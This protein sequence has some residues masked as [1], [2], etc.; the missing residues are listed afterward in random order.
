MKARQQSHP[1]RKTPPSLVEL[2]QLCSA[3]DGHKTAYTF[4]ADGESEADSLTY[5]Q[6]DRSAKQ[7]AARLQER[8]RPGE[9][10]LLIYG[11][12]LEFVSAFFGCLYAGVIAVP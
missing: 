4:L 12:G 10:T 5:S 2:V 3:E 11:P 7:I 9:R 6:L 8:V 1:G